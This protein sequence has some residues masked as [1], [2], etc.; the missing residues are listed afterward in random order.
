MCTLMGILHY[1]YV[2]QLKA[3]SPISLYGH[4]YTSTLSI[5]VRY[6]FMATTKTTQI[7]NITSG[8]CTVNYCKGVRS[9]ESAMVCLAVT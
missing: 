7:F 5:Y 8:L 2:C 3:S 6:G 1:T 4:V 9:C